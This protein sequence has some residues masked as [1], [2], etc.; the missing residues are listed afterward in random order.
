MVGVIG[1]GVV[2]VGFVCY[3]VFFVMLV[4][5]VVIGDLIVEVGKVLV[6]FLIKV[7]VLV[8][9]IGG[10]QCDLQMLISVVGVSIIGGDIVDYGLW[11]VFW[12]FLVQ[13]NFILVVINLLLL[14]LFDGGYIVVVVFERICNM[15]WL[16]CGKVVVVLVNYFK[17]LLVIYVVLVFVVGYMFLIVIVDLVNLIR[18]FQQVE[19]IF[20]D[21]R[22]GYVVVFGIY[23]CFLVCYLL[24]DGW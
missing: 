9:V 6:V 18:F 23:V 4:I 20:S 13:L 24:V 7:G 11:V 12:F 15:V 8:W 3:G 5:F 1:V 21:C 16:V 14:L 19:R 10:G 17:F 22:F 2:W